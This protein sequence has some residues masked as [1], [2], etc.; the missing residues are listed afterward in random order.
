M[1]SIGN[2]LKKLPSWA[3]IFIC[4]FLF[5]FAAKSFGKN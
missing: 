1:K 4:C 2:A 3:V 5:Y